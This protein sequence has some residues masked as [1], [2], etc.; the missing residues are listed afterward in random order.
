L[1]PRS[2]PVFVLMAVTSLFCLAQ[3]QGA[4]P[5]SYFDT[6]SA[7]KYALSNA[8][9]DYLVAFDSRHDSDRKRVGIPLLSSPGNGFNLAYDIAGR[10]AMVQWKF[11]QT[12]VRGNTLSYQ[13]YLGE[14]GAMS[15]VMGA[16]F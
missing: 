4:L 1:K 2:I 3:T 5:K 16:K 13:A 8:V 6:P 14:S 11:S 10:N 12:T 7:P 9:G 15:F